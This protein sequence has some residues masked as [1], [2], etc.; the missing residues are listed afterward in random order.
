MDNDKIFDNFEDNVFR[1]TFYFKAAFKFDS[2]L[3][4]IL[5]KYSIPPF[6][7][8]NRLYDPITL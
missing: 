3:G 4:Q 7:S 6:D 1:S 5:F 8:S 2:V